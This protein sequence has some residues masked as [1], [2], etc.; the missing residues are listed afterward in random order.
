MNSN[1][2]K[3]LC[4]SPDSRVTSYKPSNAACGRDLGTFI[5]KDLKPRQQRITVNNKADRM[6]GFI[7]GSAS[8]RSKQCDFAPAHIIG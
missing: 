8:N 3:A 1:I 7:S 2:G 4:K 6:R 5:S